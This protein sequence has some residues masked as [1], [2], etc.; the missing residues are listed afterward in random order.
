MLQFLAEFFQKK[1][2]GFC[3]IGIFSSLL[4]LGLLY[5]FTEHFH[6]WYLCSATAS[7]IVGMLA[8]YLLNK[9][10]NFHDAS[11]KYVRQFSIFAIISLTGLSLNLAILT[12]AVELFAMNY[13]PAKIIAIA[14]GFFW[15]Y[16]G[17]SKITFRLTE[18]KPGDE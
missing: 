6:I 1:F 15:N 9:Y 10:L 16:F 18:T 3:L 11:R 8:S 12:A 17:Q 2:I 4:D 7:Y 5:L 14:T 13:I